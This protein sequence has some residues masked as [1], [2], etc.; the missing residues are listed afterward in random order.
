[1]PLLEP[2]RPLTV[3]PWAL[4]RSSQLHSTMRTILGNGHLTRVSRRTR[5]KETIITTELL[6]LHDEGAVE[7]TAWAVVGEMDVQL[8]HQVLSSQRLVDI[9]G[10]LQASLRLIPM[11]L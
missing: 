6:R 2:P 9:Q 7:V 5:G 3:P 11:T 4:F 8:G 1:M 10:C